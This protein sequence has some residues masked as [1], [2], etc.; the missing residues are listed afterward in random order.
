MRN[1]TALYEILNV[2]HELLISY[3]RRYVRFCISCNRVSN[4]PRDFDRHRYASD[5]QTYSRRSIR[6]DIRP[7]TKFFDRLRKWYREPV[8]G[9]VRLDFSTIFPRFSRGLLEKRM[10]P[11]HFCQC[12]TSGETNRKE[13]EVEGRDLA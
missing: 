10:T 11:P 9:V 5:S 8:V 6:R 3:N 1:E 4:I 12:L 7:C 13:K 2:G